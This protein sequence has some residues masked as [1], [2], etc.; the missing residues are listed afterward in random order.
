MRH[1]RIG[2]LF[3]AVMLLLVVA[4]GAM[5]S[6]T[7]GGKP[8]VPA[9]VAQVPHWDAVAFSELPAGVPE[10]PGAGF[11]RFLPCHG[12][13]TTRARDRP[14]RSAQ[15]IRRRGTEPDPTRHLDGAGIA[16]AVGSGRVAAGAV[17]APGPV[18]LGVG[19]RGSPHVVA[20]ATPARVTTASNA[21]ARAVGSR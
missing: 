19:L 16:D 3:A 10:L 5:A 4:P 11:R 14:L 7:G 2:A 18:R 1:C 15:R 9:D 20:Q 12:S 21:S 8:V 17:P 6:Q 13:R